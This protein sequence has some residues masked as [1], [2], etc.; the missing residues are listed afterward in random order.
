MQ[1]SLNWDL[2]LDTFRHLENLREGATFDK[3]AGFKL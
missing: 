3:A 2:N 1:E